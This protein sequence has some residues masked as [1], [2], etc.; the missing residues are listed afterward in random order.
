[1]NIKQQ[2]QISAFLTEQFGEE[3][4]ARLYA[5]QKKLLDTL[6]GNTTGKSENQMKT[7]AWKT[8]AP[9]CADCFAT[10]TTCPTADCAKWVFLARKRLA[11]AAIVA[12]STSSKRS[13]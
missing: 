9:S 3:R 12:T 11:T 7:L 1:M 13:S 8:I 2:K 10:S 4:S 5:E 6:I